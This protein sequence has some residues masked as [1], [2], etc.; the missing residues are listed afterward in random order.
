[1]ESIDKYL[2][3]SQHHLGVEGERYGGGFRA[4]VA[5]RPS[6]EFLFGMLEGDDLEGTE[7]QS[8][9][10]ENPLFPSAWGTTASEALKKLNAKLTLLYHFEASTGVYKWK[11]EPKFSLLA[12]YDS[13]PGEVPQTY[14]VSWA[15]VVED[16]FGDS[17]YFYEAAK[18]SCSATHKRDLH[19][20][21]NF[22]YEGE[23]SGLR[24]I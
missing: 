15:D 9:F 11:A 22:E 8:F 20:L 3:A 17:T 16:L 6:T 23:L 4:I 5:P 24:D 18:R 7:A 13:R 12:N 10:A 14:K 21:L 1:M 19:A 2:E